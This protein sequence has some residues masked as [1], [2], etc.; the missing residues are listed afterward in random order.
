MIA[1]AALV[2]LI[3]A[4]VTI[5][6]MATRGGHP[7]SPPRALGDQ[8]AAWVDAGLIDREQAAGI[9]ALEGVRAPAPAAVIAAVPAAAAAAPPAAPPTTT[10]RPALAAV[11]EGLG[12]LGGVLAVTGVVLLVAHFWEELA[13]GGQ[14]ALSGLTALALAGAGFAVPERRG[15]AMSRLRAFLWTLSTA[16]VAVFAAV[17]A[18]EVLGDRPVAP[19]VACTAAA[20][21]LTSG[22]MWWGRARPVQQLVALAAAVVAIGTGLAEPAGSTVAGLAVWIAGAALLAVGVRRVTTFPVLDVAVGA[23]A[24]GV[25]AMLMVGDDP[26][27]DMLLVVATGAVLVTLALLRRLVTDVASIVVLSVVGAIVV[28]QSLPPL[29]GIMAGDAAVA[30]GAVMWIAGLAVLVIGVRRLTRVP[31]LLEVLGAVAMLVAC[32]VTAAESPTI[33]TIAGLVTS[34]GL[35]G[36]SMLPGRVALSPVGAVGL[37]A[38]VPWSIGW[39]FPGEGRVPLLISVSGLL[40]IGVAVLMARS[41][42]RFGRELGHHH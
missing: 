37:L 4:V 19:V 23:V 32:A 34:L 27:A 30:T 18:R 3:G 35:L 2:L 13:I 21:A 5:V 10:S 9:A 28:A 7:A 26:G 12:Y 15:P 41:G 20:V 25:G 33:A 42:H 17:A 40:I 14:L 16:S 31:I 39:F 36:V 11:I 24:T 1:I 29:I 22:L 38:Y 8:L 6:V